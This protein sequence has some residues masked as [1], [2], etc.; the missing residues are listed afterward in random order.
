MLEKP[1]IGELVWAKV[2]ELAPNGAILQLEERYQG[3]LP[4]SE[5]P[6][7]SEIVVGA[8]VVVKVIGYDPAGQPLVSMRRVSEA[9]REEAQFHREALEFRTSLSTRSL[10][11][12]EEKPVVERVEWRLARWLS[13][14]EGVLRRRRSRP[15]MGLG[16]E[17]E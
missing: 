4:L 1:S 8:E 7:E 16:E 3:F 12:L 5:V 2:L 11:L 14:A 6:P 13:Q 17:K 9:D 15:P 10:P